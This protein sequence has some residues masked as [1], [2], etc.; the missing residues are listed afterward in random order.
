MAERL[1][2]TIRNS[3]FAGPNDY[4]DTFTV[5]P[6]P[7]HLGRIWS[8]TL[9][10]NTCGFLY[11]G[12]SCLWTVSTSSCDV[13]PW[14][15]LDPEAQRS[16]AVGHLIG[17]YCVTKTPFEDANVLRALRVRCGKKTRILYQILQPLRVPA[18]R[19]A[20]KQVEMR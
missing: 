4:F 9:L 13:H 14:S 15:I 5:V 1:P 2:G 20:G 7:Y 11:G 17:K 12:V 19:V 6:W 8:S 16:A 18:C 3:R 10:P